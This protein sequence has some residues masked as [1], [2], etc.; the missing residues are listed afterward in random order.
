MIQDENT[1]MWLAFPPPGRPLHPCIVQR[2][3]VAAVV[4]DEDAPPI[5]REGELIGVPRTSSAL[6]NSRPH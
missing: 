6:I 1:A 3:K 4:R 5:G 2:T